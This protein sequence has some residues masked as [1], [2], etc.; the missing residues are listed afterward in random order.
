MEWQQYEI[1]E[2]AAKRVVPTIASH[3]RLTWADVMLPS[4]IERLNEYHDH[5]ENMLRLGRLCRG[6]AFGCDLDHSGDKVHGR[7]RMCRLGQLNVDALNTLLTHNTM[8]HSQ[9]GYPLGSLE[10]AAMHGWPKTMQGPTERYW[11]G[12][13]K[14]RVEQSNAKTLFKSLEMDG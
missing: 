10:L 11:I 12:N 7:P 9:K 1:D 3:E 2:L 8:F 4:Q 6:E 14:F 13:N 5:A